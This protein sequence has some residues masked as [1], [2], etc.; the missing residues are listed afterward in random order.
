MIEKERTVATTPA[1]T[2]RQWHPLQAL[3]GRRGN[4][5]ETALLRVESGPDNSQNCFLTIRVARRSR[6]GVFRT[7]AMWSDP[8]PAGPIKNPLAH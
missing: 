8:G 3:R 2:I 7:I 1:V 5:G 6:R 4:K